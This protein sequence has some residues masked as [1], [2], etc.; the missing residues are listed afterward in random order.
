MTCTEVN[1]PG[2]P[3]RTVTVV[4]SG[5]P[6]SGRIYPA[7]A[8]TAPADGEAVVAYQEASDCT[9]ATTNGWSEAQSSGDF[10]VD[11]FGDTGF[12]FTLHDAPMSPAPLGAGISNQNAMGTFTLAGSGLSSFPF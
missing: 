6:S 12:D 4:F 5:I 11:V 7:V 2:L 3:C 10:T 8:K 9:L 1:G